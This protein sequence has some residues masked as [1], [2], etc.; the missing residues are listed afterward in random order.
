MLMR[1]RQQVITGIKS[2]IIMLLLGVLSLDP[3][4]NILRQ[5]NM[6]RYTDYFV[7]QVAEGK[8]SDMIDLPDSEIFMIEGEDDLYEQE[9]YADPDDP[10]IDNELLIECSE[11]TT[12][13][14]KLIGVIE[15]PSINTKVPVWEGVSVKAL[16]FG[17]GRYPLSSELGSDSGNCFIMGHRNRHIST[18]F[19]RL[20]YI[21]KG[22]KVYVATKE[23]PKIEYTVV[24]KVC[25]P[26]EKVSAYISADEMS[27]P[28]LS[29]CT[30]ISEKGK[31]WR[32]IAICER[33]EA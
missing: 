14:L 20:Q 10:N 28:K 4:V 18:I 9:E 33:S 31:G 1:F 13:D 19:C 26:P 2:V 3:L 30:C 22:A 32:F 11:K 29:L 17:V 23:D 27:A 12:D 15:I 16:R 25:V 7:N 8:N 5:K 21:E 24:D 6:D